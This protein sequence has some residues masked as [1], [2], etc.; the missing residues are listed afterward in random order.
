MGGVSSSAIRELLKAVQQ[1]GMISFAGGMPALEMLP[2]DAVREAS[3]RV[4]VEQGPLALQYGLTEGYPPLRAWIVEYLARQ[5]IALEEENVLIITGGQQGLDLTARLLLNPGDRVV[6]ESPTFLGALQAFN[7]YQTTYVP[8]PMDDEGVRIES[9]E[10]ALATG[11]RFIYAI[12]T[13]QNPSGVTLSQE[14]RRALVHLASQAGVP[15]LEDDPYWQLRYEGEHSPSLLA[16]DVARFEQGD[17][18]GNIIYLGSFSKILGPGLRLGWIAAPA[19]VIKR[20]VQAKQGVD[21]HTSLYVQM[22]VHE[23]VSRSG[24][25]EQLV[26]RLQTV[27]RERRD[28]ML[29]AMAQHFPPG[30]SWTQPQGGLFLWVTLPSSLNAE[31]L[32]V[33]ALRHRVA[34]VPGAPFYADGNAPHVLRLNF[35]YS[36]P[37]QIEEGI[38][39]LGGVL[40][41][42]LE[43]AMFVIGG[44]RLQ[45]GILEHLP[46]PSG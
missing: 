42:A 4:L 21:L 25:L 36:Q 9:L 14:R 10:A 20:M 40:T 22:V 13:F 43:P 5:G 15:I 29:A 18:P 28:V 44:H 16:L 26:A 27:Y 41:R 23:V 33:E 32:L 12:P 37:E 19:I 34:F 45:D 8:V 46:V 11:P 2:T 24:F 17:A 31:E 3:Q 39:R 38:Q 35:S 7:A 30:V 6:V 1:P